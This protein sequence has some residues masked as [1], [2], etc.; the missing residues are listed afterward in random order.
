MGKSSLWQFTRSEPKTNAHV[1]LPLGEAQ[2]CVDCETI[3]DARG[4]VCPACDGKGGL[5]SLS[6]WLGGGLGPWEK[7]A[8]TPE[9]IVTTTV[10]GQELNE[11]GRREGEAQGEGLN[12]EGKCQGGHL[13]SIPHEGEKPH[14]PICGEEL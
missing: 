7:R 14:C 10:D 1:M 9:S 13:P 2:L 11:M 4:E 6:V 5:V 8:R 12:N 3:T